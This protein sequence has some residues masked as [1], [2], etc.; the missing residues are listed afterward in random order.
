MG[1]VRRIDTDLAVLEITP[2]GV[3]VLDCVEGLSFEA[4]QATTDVLR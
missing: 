1:C 4:L 3:K 2:A